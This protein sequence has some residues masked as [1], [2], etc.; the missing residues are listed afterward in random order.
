MRQIKRILK[1]VFCLPPLSTVLIAVPSFALVIYVL[2]SEV[3]YT[4]LS[5]IAYTASAYAMII[6]VTGINGIAD[7]ARRNIN[8]HPIMKKVKRHPLGNRYVSDRAF[9]G[10]VSLYMGLA[11]NLCYA[12]F[13]F[14]TGGIYGSVWLAAIGVY[15]LALSVNRAFLVHCL[16]K[17]SA[18]KTKDEKPEYELRCYRV[19]GIL[20]LGLNAAMGRMILQMIC[21]NRGYSYP[22]YVIYVSA[23]YAFYAF[24][25]AVMNLFAYR[26][27]GSPIL[28]ASKAISFV[29]ALMSVLALQTAMIDRFDSGRENF[30]RFMNTITGT[31][32]VVTVIFVAVFMI[33]YAN[34]R[35]RQ[36]RSR[37]HKI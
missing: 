16:R 33:V 2:A 27:V 37:D 26:R 8:N 10:E 1:K 5:Y 32:V 12:V 14:L 34:K 18:L 7:S 24:I 22:G 15:Y 23:M 3:E 29:G 9:R 21:Q 30:R 31:C 13:K 6:T 20:M 36:I 19:T 35:L 25:A 11:V 17:S 28:S 4:V